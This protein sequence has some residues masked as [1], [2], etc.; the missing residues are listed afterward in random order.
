MDDNRKGKRF[1]YLPIRTEC[2]M[3][4]S[5]IANRCSGSIDTRQ[6]GTGIDVTSITGATLKLVVLQ[7]TCKYD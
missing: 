4:Y 2:F 6:K 5:T 1:C 7:D 3:I